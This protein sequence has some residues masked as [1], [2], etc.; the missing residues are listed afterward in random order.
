MRPILRRR[1]PPRPRVLA[2][3]SWFIITHHPDRAAGVRVVVT[4]TNGYAPLRLGAG[5]ADEL[6]LALHEAGLSLLPES[7]RR[8]GGNAEAQIGRRYWP[9]SMSPPRTAD[10]KVDVRA[11]LRQWDKESNGS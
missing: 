5:D 9:T 1:R 6:G 8:R 2:E 4:F 3:S 7:A 10:G 11:L